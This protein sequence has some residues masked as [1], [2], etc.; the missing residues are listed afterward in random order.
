MP[1]HLAVDEAVADGDD[2]PLR[3]LEHGVEVHV[4][5]DADVVLARRR[6]DQHVRE[7]QQR[8]QDGGGA[9]GFP[10]GDTNGRE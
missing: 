8:Q 6:D 10:A 9:H 4:D 3:G 2:E 7:A 1:S 5:A